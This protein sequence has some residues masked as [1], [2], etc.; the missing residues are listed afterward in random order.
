MP[1]KVNGIE[2][3]ERNRFSTYVHPHDVE[4]MRDLRFWVEWF[5]DNDVRTALVLTDKGYAVYR[6]QM[7]DICDDV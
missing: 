7:L 4:G 6:E 3:I 2:V 1:Q 5:T